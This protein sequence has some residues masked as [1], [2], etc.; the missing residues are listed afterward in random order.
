[1]GAA[2]TDQGE[3][4]PLLASACPLLFVQRRDE[5]AR[6]CMVG[7]GVL[8]G[9][10]LAIDHNARLPGCHELHLPT[11]LSH[12]LG[13]VVAQFLPLSEPSNTASSLSEK[14]VIL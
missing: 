9:D 14:M 1:M 6:Q 8:T 4:A 13:R 12:N 3:L 7:E 2:C 5:G 10:K 11:G